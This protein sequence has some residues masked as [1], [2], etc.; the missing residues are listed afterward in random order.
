M[1]IVIISAW[2]YPSLSPRAQRST[3][4]AKEFAKRGNDVIV[5]SLLGDFSYFNFCKRSKIT[6]KNL[7]K[8]FWGYPNSESHFVDSLF[9][10]IIKKVVGNMLWLPDRELIPMVKKAIEKE[11]EIDLLITVAIPHVINYAASLCNK[12]MIKN[13]ISDCG[14][15]FTKNPFTQG[16][17]PRYLERYERRWCEKCNH[18]VVPV[19]SA[20]KGYFPE[21][22]GKIA[23]IPQ[24]YDFSSIIVP[25]YKKNRIVTFAYAGAFYRELRDPS[26]FLEYLAG[27]NIEFEFWLFGSSWSFACNFKDGVLNQ[28]IFNGGTLPR[29][30][31][32]PKLASMDF[33]IN[34]K[35]KSSVQQPSKLIDYALAKRP[36]L[37]I[38]SDFKRHEQ[39]AFESFIAGDY[40]NKETL[41][42]IEQ[43]D[44]KNVVDKFISLT[45]V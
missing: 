14:D 23:V 18:I 27:L 29:E 13:W 22:D 32:I 9:T 41:P 24:G 28:H 15:P 35:N 25:E 3:E 26:N 39:L 42:D 7:G 33:L 36:V 17:Y 19:D 16:L 34:M 44:I 4:L 12:S 43:Y 37:S 30:Q 20:R 40:S 38:S 5:Y 31:L 2:F 6:V 1:K 45:N 21:Y 11:Q 8:S 10:R